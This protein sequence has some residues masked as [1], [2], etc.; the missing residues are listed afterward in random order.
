MIKQREHR[1]QDPQSQQQIRTP[2]Q[3]NYNEGPD[4]E[5][6]EEISGENNLF[7]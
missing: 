6:E 3:Q 4:E 5:D 2:F 1:G 7:E